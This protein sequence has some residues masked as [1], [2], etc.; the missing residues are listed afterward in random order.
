MVPTLL[1]AALLLAQV[2]ALAAETP[3][4]AHAVYWK[5]DMVVDGHNVGFLQNG[6]AYEP[7][8]CG[9]SIYVPLFAVGEWTASSVQWDQNT[10]QIS[11]RYHHLLPTYYRSIYDM[12]C[13]DGDVHTAYMEKLDPGRT[14]GFDVTVLTDASVYGDRGA[15]S[16]VTEQ[17]TPLY[18]I[19]YE[20]VP[21]LPMRAVAQLTDKTLCYFSSLCKRPYDSVYLCD[22][23]SQEQILAAYAY[24]DDVSARV[25]AVDDYTAVVAQAQTNL[26]LHDALV[27]LQVRLVR[28]KDPS[29]PSISPLTQE[30]L[31]NMYHYGV[32]GDDGRLA[33]DPD[34][35]WS[36]LKNPMGKEMW[37]VRDY[38]AEN[39]HV[40]CTTLNNNITRMRQIVDGMASG[41][42][43]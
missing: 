40:L 30:I 10:D 24:L 27:E 37:R 25:Q 39:I 31:T 15:V 21:Y 28:V 3:V 43:R 16:T 11:V 32:D 26:Q 12:D 41:G 18:P 14:V 38:H 6:Q 5:G 22:K 4:T 20:G 19:A 42:L 2:P 33:L 23:P 35:A 7:I 17:G 9:G 8:N 36:S 13:G 34:I 29:I 1:G